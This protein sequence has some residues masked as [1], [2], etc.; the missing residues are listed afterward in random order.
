MKKTT[1]SPANIC[2]SSFHTHTLRPSSSLY[3]THGPAVSTR[4]RLPLPA[5]ALKE[6]SLPFLSI[7]P[8]TNN[9]YRQLNRRYTL[10]HADNTNRVFLNPFSLSLPLRLWRLYLLHFIPHTL[11]AWHS[12]FFLFLVKSF[13]EEIFVCRGETLFTLVITDLATPCSFSVKWNISIDDGKAQNVVP[14]FLI[15]RRLIVII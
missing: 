14:T 5:G 15:P 4:W 6:A 11:I 9:S 7:F 12:S 8:S 2:L 1:K 3:H 10:G 13:L